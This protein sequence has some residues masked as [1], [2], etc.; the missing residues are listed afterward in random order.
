MGVGISDEDL[1]LLVQGGD[2]RAFDQLVERY[3]TRM[4]AYLRQVLSDGD[5]AL[6]AA[7]EVFIRVYT[8]AGQYDPSAPFRA[9][10][11]KIATHHGIDLIRRRKRRRFVSLTDSLHS[12]GRSSG[13]E[14]GGHGL[15]EEPP[16]KER[17][18]LSAVLQGETARKVR[19]AIG[20]LPERYRTA[21]VLRDLQDLG[22]VEIA[23]VLG[24]RVGTAKSRVN[25]ARNLL[26][27]K[28]ADFAPRAPRGMEASP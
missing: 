8:R 7:Q 6:D 27:D 1:M 26:R 23:E 2:S 24:C 17:G 5:E 13:E 3:Q 19:G 21:L 15:A 20:T 9:W 11:Y 18:A 25:R 22:Y 16:S 4:V 12:L 28:L 14:D 10:L